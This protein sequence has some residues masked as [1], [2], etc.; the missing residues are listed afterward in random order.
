MLCDYFPLA[1]FDSPESH[2]CIRQLCVDERP[3]H[4]QHVQNKQIRTLVDPS[5]QF[6]VES[7]TFRFA[8][9][10]ATPSNSADRRH[11]NHHWQ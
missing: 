6:K 8:L 1:P 9:V 11:M 2:Q 10:D 5:N 4:V 3:L 7:D